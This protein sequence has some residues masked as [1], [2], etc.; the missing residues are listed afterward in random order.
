MVRFILNPPESNAKACSEVQHET[1]V[2]FSVSFINYVHTPI[3][4]RKKRKLVKMFK[5]LKTST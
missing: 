1:A 3:N 2:T 4:K 5:F